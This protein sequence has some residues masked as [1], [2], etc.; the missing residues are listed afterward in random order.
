MPVDVEA[1]VTYFRPYRKN[2][3]VQDGAYGMFVK[4]TTAVHLAPGD[5]V[6]IKGVTRAGYLPDVISSDITLLGHGT[7]PKPVRADYND[8]LGPRYD[9]MLVTV[10]GVVRAA[11]VDAP[12]AAHTPGST[13]KILSDGGTVDVEL[14]SDDASAMANLLDAEV[15]VT[16][17]A[18]GRL[19]GKIRRSAFCC[20]L[21]ASPMSKS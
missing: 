12:S 19:D 6:Q 2:M 1:T 4:A 18:G 13:L 9:S 7:L 15:E 10:R 5:R 3:F 16:G 21:P 8:L 14:D 11:N 20:T 17:A